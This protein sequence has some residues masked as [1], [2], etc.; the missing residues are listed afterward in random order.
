MSALGHVVFICFHFKQQIED[1]VKEMDVRQK[2]LEKLENKNNKNNKIKK[3]TK[4]K[5]NR[6]IEKIK[7]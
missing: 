6:K 7:K 1:K 5:Q 3:K 4:I 2:L